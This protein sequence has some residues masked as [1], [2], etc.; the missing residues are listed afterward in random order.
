MEDSY[1]KL[2]CHLRGC[3]IYFTII[4]EVKARYET[5]RERERAILLLLF[6]CIQKHGVWVSVVKAIKWK[7]PNMYCCCYITDTK[8]WAN[9]KETMKDCYLFSNITFQSTW[10][11]DKI[12]VVYKDILVCCGF[13]WLI[14]SREILKSARSQ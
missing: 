7:L 4:I 8:S 13:S 3:T 2:L 12:F 6:P 5:K 11:N 10:C 1:L 9:I 14:M